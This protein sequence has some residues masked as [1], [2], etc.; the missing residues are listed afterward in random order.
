MSTYL[1]E[2]K[3]AVYA[4]N[5]IGAVIDITTGIRTEKKK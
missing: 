2:D 4:I 3:W 1:V 5:R